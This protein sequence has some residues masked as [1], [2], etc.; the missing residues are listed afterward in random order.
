MLGELVYVESNINS[1]KK[2]FDLSTLNNGVY[3]IK[4]VSENKSVI[5]KFA[6]S[7]H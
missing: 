5:Q 2:I 3:F 7:A 6:I 1:T 4:L